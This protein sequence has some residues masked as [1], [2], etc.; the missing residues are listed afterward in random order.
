MDLSALLGAPQVSEDTV[1]Q[2][3]IGT[4][5][6][7][8]TGNT[9]DFDQ[10]NEI[11]DDI[12]TNL[13]D[14]CP[15]SNNDNSTSTSTNVS[16]PTLSALGDA[17]EAVAEATTEAI[18]QTVEDNIL[19]DIEAPP[20]STPTQ[21]ALEDTNA[22]ADGSPEGNE[23]VEISEQTISTT[24]LPSIGFANTGNNET[25]DPNDR[26]NHTFSTDVNEGHF[27]GLTSE[28]GDPLTL[29][30]M[31]MDFSYNTDHNDGEVNYAFFATP[32]L[33]SA[34][35]FEST[36]SLDYTSGADS[37]NGYTSL[38]TETNVESVDDLIGFEA[39]VAIQVDGSENLATSVLH[40][41]AS[42]ILDAASLGS[43]DGDEHVTI[44]FEA[45]YSPEV[46]ILDQSSNSFFGI[47]LSTSF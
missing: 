46:E 17:S 14:P 40:S 7:N 30:E 10:L 29:S 19:S 5:V 16:G 1:D 20:E 39:A 3:Q 45:E 47:S 42:T 38:T 27:S 37:N 26:S 43:L 41:T 18:E 24:I 6:N 13:P 44:G 21:E 25:A 2:T 32:S 4:N 11:V 12:I 8:A 22:D 15:E 34:S 9:V 23:V 31:V 36:Q 33:T 28:S 35:I